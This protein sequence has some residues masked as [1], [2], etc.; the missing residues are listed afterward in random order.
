MHGIGGERPSSPVKSLPS[1]DRI[2]YRPYIDHVLDC[3]GFDRTLFGGDRPVVLL[4]SKLTRGPDFGAEAG[5]CQTAPL[6]ISAGLCLEHPCV[7]S[8]DRRQLFVRPLL[9]QAP[10]IEHDD[11]IGQADIGEPVGDH[12]RGLLARQ[13]QE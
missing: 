4:A 8:V 3:F 5:A 11:V 12:H 1:D 10:G 7:Q 13:V 9:G 6:P 2:I